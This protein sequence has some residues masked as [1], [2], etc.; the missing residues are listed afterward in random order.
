[1]SRNILNAVF[2]SQLDK[3]AEK[4]WRKSYGH[5]SVRTLYNA[6]LHGFIFPARRYHRFL[7]N[8]YLRQCPPDH[9]ATG[10]SHLPVMFEYFDGKPNFT[11]PTTMK[12]PL[13]GGQLDGKRLYGEVLKR[14]TTLNV[15]SEEV[16]QEG[17]KQLDI[18]YPK[19][20]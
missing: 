18:F 10:L 7:K 14:Y 3:N 13:T 8:E 6:L 15:T 9:V 12:L 2:Y 1:M 11:K 16:Y 20:S 17:I 4:K 5:S 19:V